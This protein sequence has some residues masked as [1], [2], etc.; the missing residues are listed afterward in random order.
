MIIEQ[1]P[2]EGATGS[3]IVMQFEILHNMR[4]IGGFAYVHISA[5]TVEGIRWP[6]NLKGGSMHWKVG[7][8]SKNTKI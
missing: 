2:H 7:G 5:L 8:Y 4:D 1:S 6:K 3:E